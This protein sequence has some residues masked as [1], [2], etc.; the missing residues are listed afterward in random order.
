MGNFLRKHAATFVVAAVTAVTLGGVPALAHFTSIS[1][2]DL[3]HLDNDYTKTFYRRGAFVTIASG[4]TNDAGVKCPTG[5]VALGGGGYTTASNMLLEASYPSQ[6]LSADAGF[7]GWHIYV[8]NN[9]GSPND[10]RAYVICRRAFSP[11][12]SNYSA[13]SSPRGVGAR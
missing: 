6:G 13:G 10:A 5:T 3:N 1:G 9:S 7:N 2:H 8:R 4:A 12:N 11:S